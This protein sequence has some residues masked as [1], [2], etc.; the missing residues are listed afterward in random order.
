[1]RSGGRGGQALVP[2]GDQ[3]Q[4][5]DVPDAPAEETQQVD[6]GLVGPVDVLDDQHVQLT[7][8]ADLP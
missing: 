7:R 5:R 8:R 6:G 3:K 4:H 2:V 1:M